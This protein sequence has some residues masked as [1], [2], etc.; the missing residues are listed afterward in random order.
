MTRPVILA[1]AVLALTSSAALAFDYA[2]VSRNAILFEASSL[3]AKKLAIIRTGTPVE[4]VITT[5]DQQW[6]RVRDP[7]GAL[8]WIESNALSKQRTVLVAAGQATARREANE[9]SAVVFEV[10]RDVVLEFVS[11]SPNGWV[12]VR[13]PDGEVGFLRATEVWGL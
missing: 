5:P 3:Q 11:S 2:S 6:A 12:R 13:H 7:S 4:I 1:A 8:S 10:V 9:R